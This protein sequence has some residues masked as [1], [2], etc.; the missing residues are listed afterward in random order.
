MV[1]PILSSSACM[2]GTERENFIASLV[3]GEVILTSHEDKAAAVDDFFFNLIGTSQD[4]DQTVDLEA[5]NL[6]HH[7]LAE[8]EAPCS[9]DE[10]WETI[11]LLP[12]DKAPGPDGFTGCFYKSCWNTIKSDIM[13]AISATWNRKFENLGKLNSPY[14][15][16]IPKKE[17][18]DHVEFRPISLVHSF[19]KLITKILANKLVSRL[20]G[21]I[22]P[23][24][25]A[26]I[27]GR[28]IQDNFMLM[29]QTSRFLHRHK[30]ASL[31][32]KLDITKAFDSISW[33]FLI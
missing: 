21:M 6:S 11:K 9:E 17:G 2:L 30:K 18:A 1:M 28:F 7:D 32:L 10:V 8:L 16:L 27:K 14:I 31:L 3:D 13:A 33:P 22:S 23:N 26:F 29:Q 12:S 20:N 19:G 24:Q 15:S 25:S 4:R 5:L